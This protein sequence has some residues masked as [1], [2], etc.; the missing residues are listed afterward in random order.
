[1]TLR[2]LTVLIGAVLLTIGAIGLLTPVSA[3]DTEGKSV[4]CGTTL[5]S[6]LSGARAANQKTVASLPIISQVVPHTD[7]VAECESALSSRRAW[8]IPLAVIGAVVIAGA[9]VAPVLMRGRPS[10]T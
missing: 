10:A 9:L 7:Y 4:S 2:R 3:T 6:D 1:M 8:T 5:V